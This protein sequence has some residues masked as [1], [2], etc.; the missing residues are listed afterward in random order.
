MQNNRLRTMVTCALMAAMLAI[1]A[2]IAIPIGDTVF[3]LQ[4]FGIA[5]SLLLLG[6]KWG[7]VCT[8]L[9]L[10]LGIVG[11]PVFSGFRG[12]I[13]ILLGSTGGYI[14]GFLVWA[15]IYWLT[16]AV[17]GEKSK[18]IA[19][20]LGL[21]GCYLFGSLW[22]YHLY[23]KSPEMI[24]FTCVLPYLLPDAGKLALAWLLAKK[25]KFF[26]YR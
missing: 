7:T 2:W 25:L 24:L 21:I 4:T 6:G 20:I 9:Y 23:A 15:L 16:T 5:L 14:L 10:A 26:V 1:C 18:C 12:G 13:G 3:T 22:F 11:L 17:A 19:L 8:C